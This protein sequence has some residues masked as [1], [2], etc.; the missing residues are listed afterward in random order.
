[1]RTD[2]ITY[3]TTIFEFH[4]LEHFYKSFNFF[5]NSFCIVIVSCHNS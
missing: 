4:F 1:M 5:F 2:V 3:I